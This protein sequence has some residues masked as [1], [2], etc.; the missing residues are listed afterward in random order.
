MKNSIW[1]ESYNK[2]RKELKHIRKKAGLSQIQLA[3]KLDKPQSYVSK[4]EIGDRNLDFI[5][6]INVCNQCGI[7]PEDF[8]KTIRKLV[9]VK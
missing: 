1:E 6:V 4:Y 9:D 2:L 7:V 8:T 5:E 3:E